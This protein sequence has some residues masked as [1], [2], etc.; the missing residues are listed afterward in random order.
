MK[1]HARHPPHLLQHCLIG[2]QGHRLFLYRLEG[3]EN[4]PMTHLR[5]FLSACTFCIFRCAASFPIEPLRTMHAY[6][7]R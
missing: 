3:I 1:K 2:L 7:S 5:R 6:F 4:A